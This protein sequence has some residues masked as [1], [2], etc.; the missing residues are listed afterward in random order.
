MSVTAFLP[1]RYGSKRIK[2]KN[3]RPISN[4]PNGLVEIKLKQLLSSSLIS[5]IYL[6]TNDKTIIKYAESMNNE[7]IYI[8]KRHDSLCSENTTTDDLIKFATEILPDDDI[9]WTHVTSPLISSKDYDDI[10]KSYYKSISDGYDS[11]VTV[12]VLQSFIWDEFGPFNY[13]ENKQKWPFTQDIKKLYEINSGAFIANKDI[14]KRLNNRLGEKPKYFI[15]DKLQS[16]D[17]DN[18]DEFNLVEK[19]LDSLQ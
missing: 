13:S 5:K 17:I 6:S 8:N 1:C 3:T 11:L 19:I 2:N 14:Y 18:L 15:L 7:K 9:L 4:F 16:L 10:I 12:T